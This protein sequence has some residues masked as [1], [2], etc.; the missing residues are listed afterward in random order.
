[1]EPGIL[2]RICAVWWYIKISS[3][4]DLTPYYHEVDVNPGL[5]F[6]KAK[7]VVFI[8]EKWSIATS[9]STEFIKSTTKL[10]RAELELFATRISWCESIMIPLH[11]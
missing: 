9:V 11:I 10:S 4:E 1:M 5:V 3:Q 2:I 6:V 8:K 7:E